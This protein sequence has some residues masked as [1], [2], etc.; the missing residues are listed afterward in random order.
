MFRFGRCLRF[1]KRG[2][3]FRFGRGCRGMGRQYFKVTNDRN[4]TLDL[5]KEDQKTVL[6]TQLKDLDIRRQNIEN[7]LKK[8]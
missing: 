2:F 4:N 8:F 5:S 1:R 3:G 7:Q 6:Q